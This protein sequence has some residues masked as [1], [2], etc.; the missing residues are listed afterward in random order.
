MSASWCVCLSLSLPSLWQMIFYVVSVAEI[1]A[2]T[3]M[4][5]TSE[6]KKDY[7]SD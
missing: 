2:V 1:L 3:S 4:P 7:R 5:V 6:Y